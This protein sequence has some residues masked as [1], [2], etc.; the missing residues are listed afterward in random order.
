MSLVGSPLRALWIAAF[1]FY[2]SFQLLVPVVPL[3]GVRLG[4]SD[5]QLGLLTGLFAGTAMLLRPVVGQLT[6]SLGRRPL[7]LLGSAIFAAAPLGYAAVG[8]LA[9][10]LALR[11]LHG[12]G[13]GFG[14]TA[15]SVAAADL[16]PIA[17]RGEALGV[18]GLAS[19][20]GIMLGPYAGIELYERFGSTTTFLVATSLAAGSVA[21]AA[22]LPET[23]PPSTHA[24]RPSG[25]LSAAALYPSALYL[26][27]FFGYG[28]VVS[29]LPLFAEREQLGNPGLFYTLFALAGVAV[30]PGAGRLAD[31]LGRRVVVLPALVAAGLAL[32]LLAAGRSPVWLGAAALL[33]GIG[34]GAGTPGIFAGAVLLGLFAE[35]FG[36]RLMWW[37]A[38]C[39][40][41]LAAV[42]ALRDVRRPRG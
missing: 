39:V 37:V 19:T 9:A 1:L 26:A 3:Y 13:M 7:I 25:M 22:T 16:A 12:S 28:G 10:L 15:A 38:A 32:A 41:W 17:R 4:A 2:L 14:Q 6:D 40:P 42:A 27:F 30:R 23:R 8:G 20:F 5:V 33:Y 36:Y 21:V 11:V 31:R 34:F 35:R 24:A 18:F 29:F